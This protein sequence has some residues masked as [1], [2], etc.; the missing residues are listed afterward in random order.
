MKNVLFI[1]SF[2]IIM[3][4]CK[5]VSLICEDTEYTYDTDVK[6]I[7]EQRC[8]NAGCH[9]DGS[10]NGDFTSYDKLEPFLKNGK[11]NK[12]VFVTKDMPKNDTLAFDQKVVLQCWFENGHLEN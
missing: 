2:A 7:I 6:I 8:N 10:S 12:H 5:Q 3:L 1:F 11:F 4:S 9:D